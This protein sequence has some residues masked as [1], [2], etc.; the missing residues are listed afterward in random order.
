MKGYPHWHTF[1]NPHYEGVPVK[2]DESS[3][4]DC[5][6]PDTVVFRFET[7]R[8]LIDQWGADLCNAFKKKGKKEEQ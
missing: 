2:M 6:N 5:K 1:K 3:F 8:L 7:N 4:S